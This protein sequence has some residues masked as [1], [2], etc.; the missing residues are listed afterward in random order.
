MTESIMDQIEDLQQENTGNAKILVVGVGGGGGNA[1][2]NM[3]ELGLT[4]VDFVCANTDLQALN[5]NPAPTRVQLGEKLTRGLGA[6]ANPDVGRDAANESIQNIQAALQGAEM[7]FVTCG[8]GGGTGTGAAPIVAQ[9]AK[10]MGALT[11]GVVTRPFKFEGTKRANYARD[12]IEELS[13]HVDCLITIPNDRI[14]TFA[15]KKTPLKELMR[16]ANDV[17]YFGVKG[18]SDVITCPGYVNLDFADVRTCMHES[19]LALM[20]M[21]SGHGENRAEDAAQ[22]A[23]ASPLLD[24][25]SLESAKA[26]LYNITA[27]EDISGEE[28]EL[29]GE[30]IRSEVPENANIIFGVVFDNSLDDEIRVTVVATGIEPASPAPVVRPQ[31]SLN[32]KTTQVHPDM[33]AQQVQGAMPVAGPTVTP[34]SD[35]P[36]AGMQMR[37]RDSRNSRFLNE[38]RDRWNSERHVAPHG[39]YDF[40]F[41]SGVHNPG[42]TDVIMDEDTDMP[43]FLRKQAD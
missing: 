27:P 1:V 31:P 2:Q 19:G 26:I 41:G 10:E 34:F 9:V 43:A 12:G 38:A 40:N 11:V 29:I 39:G 21:G 8:M 14:L 35:I 18:I 13:K 4:G 42:G 7:V 24:D 20:G 32:R 25:V 17:L 28:M 22:S 33:Y 5:K 37:P 23:I 15:P 36:Q 6:G 16:K 3:I 30:K